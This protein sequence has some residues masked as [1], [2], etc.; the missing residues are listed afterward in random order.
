MFVFEYLRE[1]A[2]IIEIGI[3]KLFSGISTTVCQ[4]E[5]GIRDGKSRETALLNY[6]KP[7]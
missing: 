3:K 2:K 7:N 5:L 4:K 6:F 1:F